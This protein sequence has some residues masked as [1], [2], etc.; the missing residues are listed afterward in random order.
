MQILEQNATYSLYRDF[1]LSA[2][3]EQV[4]FLLYLPMLKSD[5]LSLYKVLYTQSYEAIVGGFY[6]EHEILLDSLGFKDSQFLEARSKLE[7]IGLLETYRKEN[8]ETMGASKVTYLYRLLPPASPKKFFR[9]TLLKVNFSSCVGKKRYFALENY[10]KAK[11]DF[12]INEEE[13]MDVTTPFKDVYQP[14][15]SRDDPSLMEVSS[16]AYPDKN[17]KSQ[18]EFDESKLNRILATLSYDAN[19]IK[20]YWRDIVSTASLYQVSEEDTANLIMTSTNFL[21][22]NTFYY[23]NFLNGMRAFHKFQR[24][25]V[26][27]KKEEYGKGNNARLLRI[28]AETAP[29]Q[30][31]SVKLN[32]APSKMMLLEIER[33]QKDFGFDN[34]IINVILDYSLRRTN[35]EFNIAFIDQVAYSLSANGVSSPNDAMVQLASR[36][37]EKNRSLSKKKSRSRKNEV[38]K[39]IKEEKDEAS[40]DDVFQV[41]E[42][43]GL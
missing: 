7:A 37:Y 43:L 2:G 39:P 36:D 41:A 16:S 6:L 12:K 17:Y 35:N 25:E 31:L 9:D 10:F 42:D 15:I 26:T 33:L 29:Q 21:D 19:S 4:L 18:V 30:F 38:D 1:T 27:K 5:A 11:A 24:K 13:Y 8:H 14:E 3:D 32:A 28:F 40:S 22:G 20:G 34:G 23:E